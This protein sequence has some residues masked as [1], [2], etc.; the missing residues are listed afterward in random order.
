[1]K[2]KKILMNIYISILIL[3]F[4]TLIVLSVLGSKERV[5]YLSGIS[6][7]TEE[8]FLYNTNN[9]E[10]NDIKN[11]NI[12]RNYAYSF[13]V[14]YYSKVFR[15]SDIYGV[16]LN[17]N[18]LPNYIKEIK[19]NNKFGVPFGI[20]FTANKLEIEKIDNIKY[21]LKVKSNIFLLFILLVILFAIFVY[22]SDDLCIFIINFFNKI[23]YFFVLKKYIIPII[24]F[25]F[26]FFILFN[27]SLNSIFIVFVLLVLFLFIK[28]L[29]SLSNIKTHY[30]I[31]IFFSFLILPTIIYNVF[32]NYF[33]KS[34]YENR[35][36][37]SKPIIDINH[38]DVYPKLYEKYFDDNIPF[39]NKLVQLKNII[40]IKIFQNIISDKILLGKDSW[41]FYKD[42]NLME[43]YIGLD[44]E[45][46]TDEELITIKNNLI[47][48]RDELKKRNIDF[49]FMICPDKTFIYEEKIPHY[50]RR[51]TNI[52]YVDKFVD[53]MNRNTDLKI[54]YPKE[55]L[56]KYKNK[57]QLYYKYD[58]HWNKLGG[59]IGYCEIM[60]K[61]NMNPEHLDN[62]IVSNSA[63]I[64]GDLAIMINF[65]KQY[66]DDNDYN[67]NY[68][69]NYK[70]IKA[71]NIPHQYTYM[72]SD[73]TNSNK[74]LVF[75]DSYTG[76]MFDYIAS[77]FYKFTFLHVSEFNFNHVLNENPDIVIFEIV[78]RE[79]KN[80]LSLIKYPRLGEI[81]IDF[82]INNVI[83]NN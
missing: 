30:I 18:S 10:I 26:A 41:L 20:L 27:I 74:L 21:I 38:L 17:T 71:T 79:L 5:G 7:N 51:K 67:I 9:L 58:T 14:S 57:Y 3:Y 78:S 70:L 63:K 42:G 60:K 23:D 55:E 6:L 73:S 13:R 82:N 8:T 15:N 1:M 36:L 64:S 37:A 69:I 83:T 61:I 32:G 81:N 25:I 45:F 56:L 76:A 72:E 53:Y 28:E 62:L 31:I 43:K 66:N 40:D 34:N 19:M 33:D 80:G 54:V 46:F 75:G 12:I 2:L 49:I 68:P 16:Y 50:V 35:V 22:I 48:F 11:D 65:I 77:S 47:Y 44:S 39:R 52:N 24:L 29:R 4:I 59:Y